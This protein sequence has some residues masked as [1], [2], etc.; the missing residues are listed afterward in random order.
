AASAIYIINDLLD[1]EVDRLH[2][3]KR[4]RPFAAGDLTPQSGVLAA[5]LCSA[6]AVTI[7]AMVPVA[8]RYLLLLYVVMAI[9][10]SVRLKRFL[11]ADL[12]LLIGFYL[13]RVLYGGM[14][15]GITVSVWLLAFSLFFFLSLAFVKRLSE[16]R[17]QQLAHKLPGRGYGPE[18]MDLIASLAGS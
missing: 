7:G 17:V 13:L 14:A 8:A 15:T 2:V 18:D 12:I 4:R 9:A 1:I 10:Y 11:I 6:L 5:V 3:R 16:L